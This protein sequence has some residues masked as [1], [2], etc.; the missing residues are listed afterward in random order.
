M[1]TMPHI[2]VLIAL[3]DAI[4][5]ALARKAFGPNKDVKPK[6]RHYRHRNSAKGEWPCLAIRY[7]SHD[8]SSTVGRDEDDYGNPEVMMELAVNLTYDF[9]LPPEFDK[10]DDGVDPDPTGF[11]T[12]AEII[13]E[14]LDLLLPGTD[15]GVN[16]LGG[17]IWDIRSDGA[18]PETDELSSDQGRVEERL[19]LL[20]RVRGD[21]PTILLK[22]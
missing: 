11:G 15:Q 7:V 3:K 22:G 16:T 19:V 17:T 1:A 10:F 12:P 9:K 6:V 14:V 18:A 13:A 8:P 2:T 20:Y 21:R 4:A 5:T